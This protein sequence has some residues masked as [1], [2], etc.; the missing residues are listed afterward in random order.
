MDN[1]SVRQ[2]PQ[3]PPDFGDN[4]TTIIAQAKLL[5]DQS[6]SNQDQLIN[7]IR[8]EDA[9]FKNVFLPLAQADNELIALSYKLSIYREVCADEQMRTA[10]HEARE[11]L[12]NFK[13]ERNC[14]YDIYCLVDAV[15]QKRETLDPE[16]QRFLGRLHR[17]FT[18]NGLGLKTT[19]EKTQFKEIQQRIRKLTTEFHTNLAKPK[20]TIWFDKSDLEGIPE[21][22]LSQFETET[23][24]AEHMNKVRVPLEPFYIGVIQQFARNGST[25]QRCSFEY[26]NRCKENVVIFKEVLILRDEKARLLGYSNHAHFR[27]EDRMA[28]NPQVVVKFLDDL[29]SRLKPRGEKEIEAL[30]EVKNKDLQARGLQP[31]ESLDLWDL[32]FYKQLLAKQQSGV[33]DQKISEYFTLE[34][35]LDQIFEIFSHLFGLHFEKIHDRDNNEPHGTLGSK[36]SLKWHEDITVYATW[37]NDVETNDSFLGY[38]YMD[39]FRRDGKRE[40]AC[41]SS[42][43]PVKL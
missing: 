12:D 42:I 34:P 17:E 38:F 10:S 14:R 29:C 5:I 43:L 21:D 33:D 35:T 24:I 41:N 11:L 22:L 18:R 2:A 26:P 4:P 23:K 13:T 7:Q 15:W 37:D 20:G 25:R 32:S 19:V 6:R 8:P 3:S 9:T 27:L 30:K 28:K 31:E 39:L 40:Q 36:S 16:S 1:R